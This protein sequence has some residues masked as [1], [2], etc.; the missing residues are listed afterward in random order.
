MLLLFAVIGLQ[1]FEMTLKLKDIATVSFGTTFRSR[2]MPAASGNLRLIQ[3]KDLGR[4]NLVH[5]GQVVRIACAQPKPT[6]FAQVGDLIFRSRGQTNTA[7]LLQEA[8]GDAIVAAPLLLIR[9]NT[10]RVV[11]EFLRW[12]INQPVSQAY[13]R[14]RSEGTSLKMVSKQS[15]EKLAVN[16]PPVEQQRQAVEFF[17]LSMQEQR[18]LEE[19]KIRKALYAQKILMGMASESCPTASN[20]NSSIMSPHLPR[21]THSNT[22]Y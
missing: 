4:D 20:K 11:P 3:M 22:R 15:L 1:I 8:A 7:A 18:L 19:I 16:L 13:L 2:I 10:K 12:W 5:L 17:R 6:Q 21:Q 9:P 14:S